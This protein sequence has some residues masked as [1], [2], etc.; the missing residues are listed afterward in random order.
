MVINKYLMRRFL[1]LCGRLVDVAC[2]QFLFMFW[3][4]DLQLWIC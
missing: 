4:V 2:E 3:L 1:N